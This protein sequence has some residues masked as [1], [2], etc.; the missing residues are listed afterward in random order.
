MSLLVRKPGLFTTIQDLGRPG[1]GRWGVS[2][3]GAMDPL[4]LTLANHDST[5]LSVTECRVVHS[6]ISISTVVALPT[7][8]IHG[9]ALNLAMAFTAAS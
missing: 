3:C 9:S 1:L 7:C 2:P 5:C 6:R 4:A 8:S